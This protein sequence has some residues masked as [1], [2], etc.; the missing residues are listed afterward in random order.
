MPTSAS[1]RLKNP[2]SPT[3]L[4][5]SP[6]PMCPFGDYTVHDPRWNDLNF[7][8]TIISLPPRWTRCVRA[9][10]SCSSRP[11]TRWTSWIRPCVKRSPRGRNCSVQ[12]V[13]QHAFKKNAGTEVTTDIV[14]LR[15]LRAGESPP[16]RR[17]K[18]RWISPTTVRKSFPSTNTSPPIPK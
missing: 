11:G 9:G 17:G 16:A 7:P 3:N 6:S 2:N 1:S 10:C 8:S 14:M 12:S 5:T 18:Q 15:K 4:S 13:A